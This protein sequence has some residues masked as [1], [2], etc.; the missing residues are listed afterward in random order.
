MMMIMFIC[1]SNMAVAVEI[2]IVEKGVAGNSMMLVSAEQKPYYIAQPIIVKTYDSKAVFKALTP[3]QLLALAIYGESRSES[4]EGK[5]AVGTAIL[6]RSDHGKQSI[7]NVI[8]KPAQFSCFSQNDKQYQRLKTIAL[9]WKQ[10]YKKLVPLRECYALARGLIAGTI[11]GHRL[12]IENC[13]TYFKTPDAKPAWAKVYRLVC[14]IGNHQ[15][16]T[17]AP[18]RTVLASFNPFFVNKGRGVLL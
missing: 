6:E 5:L 2:N 12:L 15:F 18:V 14:Q 11:V 10:S 17:E 3:T 4:T 16:Y 9:N 8:L 7:K 13:V 1:W